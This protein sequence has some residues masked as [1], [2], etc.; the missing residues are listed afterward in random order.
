M[1]EVIL[2][3]AFFYADNGMVALTEPVCLHESFNTPRLGLRINSGKTVGILCCP[4][5]AVGTH[6]EE[7]LTYPA[8]QWLRDHFP[9]CG[10]DLATGLL[11]AHREAQY[12]VRLRSK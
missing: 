7:G 10:A 3:A 1:G 6:L 2:C 8:R 12:G 11:A 9:D 4:C 5:R